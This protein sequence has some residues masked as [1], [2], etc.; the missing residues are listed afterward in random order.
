MPHKVIR[1]MDTLK[2]LSVGTIGFF[3]QFATVVD[4]ILRILIGIVTLIYISTKLYRLW[5]P[6]KT[7]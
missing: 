2:V 5:F 3:I 1:D 6:K 4:W 7:L